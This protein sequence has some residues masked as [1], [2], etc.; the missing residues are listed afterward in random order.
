MAEANQHQLAIL[1]EE[2]Q[3]LSKIADFYSQDMQKQL[4]ALDRPGKHKHRDQDTSYAQAK[5]VIFGS[6]S[7]EPQ[8]AVRE[9]PREKI[10]RAKLKAPIVESKSTR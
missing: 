8:E 5:S 10:Q 6:S 9:N 7:D 4:K 2:N 1:Q 3:K